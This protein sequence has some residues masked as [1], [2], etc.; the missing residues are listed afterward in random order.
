MPPLQIG[1]AHAPQNG[2]AIAARQGKLPLENKCLTGGRRQSPLS[3]ISLKMK[4][5]SSLDILGNP[6]TVAVFN[7]EDKKITCVSPA[8]EEGLN[9][10][11]LSMLQKSDSSM[12]PSGRLEVRSDGSLYAEGRYFAPEFFDEPLLDLRKRFD[13]ANGIT[14]S[15]R[16]LIPGGLKRDVLNAGGVIS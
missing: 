9:D 2:V 16:V 14:P 10:A 3:T 4:K 6:E 1:K 13:A 15:D 7:H 5:V 11:I 12:F 8:Q